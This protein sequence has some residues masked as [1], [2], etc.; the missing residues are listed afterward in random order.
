MTLCAGHWEYVGKK[1]QR[2]WGEIFSTIFS[3]LILGHDYS[4]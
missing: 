1:L 2:E 4:Y 3:S